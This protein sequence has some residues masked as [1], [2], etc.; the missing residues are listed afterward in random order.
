MHEV[1]FPSKFWFNFPGKF[2]SDP[3][4]IEID[5]FEA[6]GIEPTERNA[7]RRFRIENNLCAYCGG[8]GHFRNNFPIILNH[9]NKSRD[10]SNYVEPFIAVTESNQYQD[11][12]SAMFLE[13]ILSWSGGSCNTLCSVINQCIYFY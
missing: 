2:L 11:K 3:N 12:K 10:F 5:T 7:R 1:W 13:I 8:K 6:K 9:Q 4:A